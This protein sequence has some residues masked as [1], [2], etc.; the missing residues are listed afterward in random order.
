MEFNFTNYGI[1]SWLNK[2]MVF[3]GSQA[4]EAAL[5]RK[6]STRSVGHVASNGVV[7]AVMLGLNISSLAYAAPIPIQVE[8]AR[9]FVPE[10]ASLT[11]Q[12]LLDSVMK[13]ASLGDNWN[14]QGAIA[15][16]KQT[17]SAAKQIIPVLPNISAK[18]SAGIDGDGNIY[19]K[20]EKDNKTA[21]LTIE[22]SSMHLLVNTVGE[23]NLYIDDV[24]FS[25]GKL[26]AKVKQVLETQ[27]AG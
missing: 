15:P 23:Q 21:Y 11:K 7:L 26:P 19:L 9:S 17:V 6:A 3:L 25:P 16:L 13:I 4:D 18:A 12:A 22:P 20:L 27:M 14:G 1:S 2:G 8:S 5:K 10:Q 24:K